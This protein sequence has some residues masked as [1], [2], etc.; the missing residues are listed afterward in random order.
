MDGS[1]RRAARRS[2]GRLSASRARISMA[3]TLTATGTERSIIRSNVTSIVRSSRRSSSRRDFVEAGAQGFSRNAAARHDSLLPRNGRRTRS[4]AVPFVSGL[5]RTRIPKHKT[6]G[7]R[8]SGRD[9]CPNRSSRRAAS[10][11]INRP[12]RSPKRDV[13]R[14]DRIFRNCSLVISVAVERR[15]VRTPGYLPYRPSDFRCFRVLRH[16]VSFVGKN[17]GR[18]RSRPAS[19]IIK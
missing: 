19:H 3:Q 18:A 15:T 17:S 9:R 2:K 6:R 11:A 10:R 8:F 5:P 4:D 14:T 16:G 7:K 12:I 13:A 1:F